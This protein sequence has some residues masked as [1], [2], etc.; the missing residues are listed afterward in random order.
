MAHGQKIFEELQASKTQVMRMH[1]GT[2]TGD[3]TATQPVTGVGFRP[4]FLMI[5]NQVADRGIAFKSELDGVNAL[6]LVQPDLAANYYEADHIISL[7]ADGFTVGDGSLSVDQM[8]NVAE[9]YV[10]VAFG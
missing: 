3:G 5:Y 10:Y 2:Y 9:P 6:C 1:I 4:R 7:N 8:N